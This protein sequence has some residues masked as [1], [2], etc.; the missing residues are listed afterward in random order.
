MLRD[1]GAL[2]ES[3]AFTNGTHEVAAF[4]QAFAAYC[5]A[6]PLRRDRERPRRLRLALQG[7]GL[8][9]GDEVLVPAMTF[10]AT[11]EAVTQA[12]GV[13][14]PVD[15]SEADY[16]IDSDAAGAAVGRRTRAVMPVH[17]YGRVANMR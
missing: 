9:P 5:G 2:L 6:E 16:C 4:E 17:L 7:L 14:V 15:V 1:I 10:V 11:F 13:P 8:E 3:G 12:G